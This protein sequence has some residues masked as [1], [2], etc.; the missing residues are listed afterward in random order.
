MNEQNYE[1]GGARL[2]HRDTIGPNCPRM[3]PPVAITYCMMLYF[4]SRVRP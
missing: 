1:I 2:V 4:N 3:R